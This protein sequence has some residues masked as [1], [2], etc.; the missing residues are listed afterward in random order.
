MR[1]TRRARRLSAA[2]L[3]VSVLATGCA[4]SVADDDS[5]PAASEA[6]DATGT[7]GDDGEGPASAGD[8]VVT[9]SSTVEPITNLVAEAFNGENPDV[10]ISVSGPGTGDG[11]AA[12]CN[13]EA[14]ISD[15]SRAIKDE[16]AAI[17]AEN[18]VTYTELY[19]A[20]DGLS[21]LTSPRTTPSSASTTATSTRCSVP[22]RPVSR[23]GRTPT[24]SAPRSVAPAT[25]R[26][27]RCRSPRPVRSRGPTTA[28]SSSSSRTSL[29]S[30]VRTLPRGRT[31]PPRRT[32]TSSSTASRA[33]RARSGGS[34][35]PSSRRTRTC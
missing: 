2:V 10:N 13:G 25:I 19:V 18:G 4:S 32:T 1:D 14:Q 8:I 15:A 11:F 16:E 22:S 21:V 24:S 7:S 20:I 27:R 33:R 29:T 5:T 3:A 9:G 26:T 23:T 35:T 12:F 6:T 31:T 34:G 17:C 28:S 30:A